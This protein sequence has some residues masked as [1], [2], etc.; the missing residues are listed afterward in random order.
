MEVLSPH[1]LS[2]TS[3]TNSLHQGSNQISSKGLRWPSQNTT[4]PAFST[5]CGI[6]MHLSVGKLRHPAM[7]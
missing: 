2:K 6:S 4:E 3:H 7:K 1:H 5:P